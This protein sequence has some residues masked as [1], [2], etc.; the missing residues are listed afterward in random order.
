MAKLGSSSISDTEVVAAASPTDDE[1]TFHYAAR[2]TT[3]EGL[4]SGES[5]SGF[6]SDRMRDRTLLTAE[7][8]KKLLRRIDWHLM[9]LCSIIFMFK[10]LDSENVRF[11][12]TTPH[13][14]RSML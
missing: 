11:K 7:E 1:D 12:Q 2:G 5:I 3:A 6:D 14:N 9:P 8:E 10:N 4:S 13:T